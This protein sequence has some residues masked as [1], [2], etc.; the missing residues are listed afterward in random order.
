[1][2]GAEEYARHIDALVYAEE[3]GFDAIGVNEHHQTAYGLMPA[4]NFRA[5]RRAAP[6][7]R[8]PTGS[9]RALC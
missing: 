1:V 2:K 5:S 9:Q 6:P 8:A 3:L 4:P 7:N